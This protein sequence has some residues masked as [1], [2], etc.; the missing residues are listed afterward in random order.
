MGE[1]MTIK[2]QCTCGKALV[3]P[4]KLQGKKVRCKDCAKIMTVPEARVDH[5][6]AGQEEEVDKTDIFHI[7]GL[8]QCPSCGKDYSK[9]QVICV[10]CG[11]NI[12]T[13]ATLYAS[14]EQSSGERKGPTE[15]VSFKDRLLGLFGF[16]KK[17]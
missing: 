5:R 4:D 17:D 3:L 6:R 7:E 14:L 2:L 16:G 1:A 13:G 11:I 15:S 12:Q 10:V 8:V 9:E